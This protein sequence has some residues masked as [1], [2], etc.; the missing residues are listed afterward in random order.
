LKKEAKRLV[1]HKRALILVREIEICEILKWW[2]WND[3]QM[4]YNMHEKTLE[5]DKVKTKEF[6]LPSDEF[7][8]N[9]SNIE[10]TQKSSSF[11]NRIK[12]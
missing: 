1:G 8:T 5:I 6:K 7:N 10:Q 2:W 4:K 9:L 12:L 11:G 3:E